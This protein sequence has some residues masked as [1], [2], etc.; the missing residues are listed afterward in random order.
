[1]ATL[2]RT[3]AVN[4]RR[5]E[6]ELVGYTR[7]TSKIEIPL[8]CIDAVIS[9]RRNELAFLTYILDKFADAYKDLEVFAAGG[10]APDVI[11]L[12]TVNDFKNR[13]VLSVQ[14]AEYLNRQNPIVDPLTGKR[15]M[16]MDVAF[17]RVLA[18]N[19]ATIVQENTDLL[20]K[21]KTLQQSLDSTLGASEV[22]IYATALA[23]QI[24]NS[25]Q[26]IKNIHPMQCDL[27]SFARVLDSEDIKQFDR[28]QP[29]AD[30]ADAE[31]Y[32]YV[33]PPSTTTTSLLSPQTVTTYV[34][35]TSPMWII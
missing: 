19:L 35:T 28:L 17:F 6:L 13:H 25:R 9:E 16:S 26:H 34:T 32:E 2:Y 23:K 7:Y 3:Q 10:T 5:Q 27:L 31:W 24:D 30:T 33:L 8:N 20:R 12:T 22:K 15:T 11:G 4:E 14:T 18:E 1:M 21:R 29:T